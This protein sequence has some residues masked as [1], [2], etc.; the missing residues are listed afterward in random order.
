MSLAGTYELVRNEG[1]EAHY[2]ALA[3]SYK[4]V[5]EKYGSSLPQSKTLIISLDG[6]KVKIDRGDPKFSS[7]YML[8]QETEETI[9]QGYTRKV[10]ATLSDNVLTIET[11]G[12]NSTSKRVFSLSGSELVV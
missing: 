8:N 12:E 10:K 11:Y 5:T 6:D 4:S 1:V 9:F 7:E 2:K 3:E